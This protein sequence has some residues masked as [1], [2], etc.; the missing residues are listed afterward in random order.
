MY[1]NLSLI[2]VKF[3]K[4]FSNV[5]RIVYTLLKYYDIPEFFIV[6]NN[7]TLGNGKWLCIPFTFNQLQVHE[8]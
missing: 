6:I 8:A 7:F 2:I 3:L 5:F 4:I 1:G